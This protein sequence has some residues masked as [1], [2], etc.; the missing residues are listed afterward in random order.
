MNLIADPRVCTR[1]SGR[2]FRK[3]R[4]LNIGKPIELVEGLV[5]RNIAVPRGHTVAGDASPCVPLV[6]MGC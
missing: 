3:K 2:Y 4:R 5:F 1:G 6:A